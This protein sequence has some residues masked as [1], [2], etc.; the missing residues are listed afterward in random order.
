M[1]ELLQLEKTREI[2]LK[3]QS[4]IESSLE[5]AEE[6]YQKNLDSDSNV[7]DSL[8]LLKYIRGLRDG[9]AKDIKKVEDAISKRMDEL[10]LSVPSNE[11]N[12]EQEPTK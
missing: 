9:I 10:G 12:P 3:S 1:E 5:T 8:S 2:L 4:D 6:L 11:S 7:E